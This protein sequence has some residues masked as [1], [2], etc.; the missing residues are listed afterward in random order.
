ML[1][2]FFGEAEAQA[3]LV[4]DPVQGVGQQTPQGNDRGK[5]EEDRRPLVPG[6]QAG[7]ELDLRQLQFAG[8]AVERAGLAAEL[9]FQ[10]VEG[11]ADQAQHALFG[12]GLRLLGAVAQL[13]QIGQ[14]LGPLL[15]VLQAL[16]HFVQ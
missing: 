13:F 4:A 10:L 11:A 2:Q 16:D 8:P 6:H 5:A 12:T 9:F 15:V 7:V 1:W 14:Q 3:D